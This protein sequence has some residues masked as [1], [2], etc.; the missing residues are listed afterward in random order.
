MSAS[1]P[2]P[3][4]GRCIR[5]Q[6]QSKHR[7]P[8]FP[9]PTLFTWRCCV[10]RIRG[11]ELSLT[12]HEES[13]LLENAFSDYVAPVLAARSVLFVPLIHVLEARED[14]SIRRRCQVFAGYL[15]HVNNLVVETGQRGPVSEALFLEEAQKSEIDQQHARDAA[16]CGVVFGQLCDLADATGQEV[17]RSVC[18]EA[19]EQASINALDQSLGL[20]G[21]DVRG[22]TPEPTDNGHARRVPVA[23]DAG[24][25]EQERS[26]DAVH[27][28]SD[29]DVFEAALDG[30]E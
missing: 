1:Q 7:E 30:L 19:P 22:H 29:L 26:N 27:C 17:E 28:D 15:Q 9:Q 10:L 14:I 6:A 16:T 20:G 24:F 2:A 4:I 3:C 5:P 11:K 23:L 12:F 18:V 13:K 21:E 25:T 8:A